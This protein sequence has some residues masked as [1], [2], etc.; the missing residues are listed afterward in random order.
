VNAGIQEPL[1][2]A[3]GKPRVALNI[4]IAGEKIAA[5][6]LIADPERIQQLGVE[7]PGNQ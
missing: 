7:I 3:G 5:I 1:V 4:T 6:D 2:R